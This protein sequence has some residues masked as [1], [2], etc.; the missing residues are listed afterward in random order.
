MNKAAK[1]PF[2]PLQIRAFVRE[3][4]EPFGTGWRLLGEE[5][6]VAIVRSRALYVIQGQAQES[7]SIKNIGWLVRAM[8]KEAG[9]EE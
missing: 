1:S 6:K 4:K 8:L 9:F 2:D 3:A 5:F 7:M